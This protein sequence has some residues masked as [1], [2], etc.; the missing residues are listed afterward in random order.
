MSERVPLYRSRAGIQH[1]WIQDGD[2]F[3]IESEFDCEPVLDR[4]KAMANENAGWNRT[5]DMRRVASIP[6]I[7]WL[8]W[9][10]EEGWDAFDAENGDRLARKLNDPD[11]AFLR[12]APGRVAPLP[13]G[14]I[15]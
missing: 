13:D 1:Y 2:S 6:L 5:R 4:N 3:R 14:G 8:K 7:V 15:R 10:N 11:W 12:T 9:L